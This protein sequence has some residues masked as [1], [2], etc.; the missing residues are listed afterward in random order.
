MQTNRLAALL[1]LLTFCSVIQFSSLKAYPQQATTASVQ[2]SRGVELYT[3]GD[4]A[5]AVNVLRQAVKEREENQ[6]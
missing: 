1:S 4:M 6:I 2:T 5:G 3:Q